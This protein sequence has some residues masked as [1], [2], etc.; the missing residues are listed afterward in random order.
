MKEKHTRPRSA[1]VPCGRRA[2]KPAG[3]R[4]RRWAFLGCLL[5][6]LVSGGLLLHDQV[7][8][9]R[10]REANAALVQQVR[11]AEEQLTTQQEEPEASP[12]PSDGPLPQ[13]QALAEQNPDFFGWIRIEGTQLD[14]PVMYTPDRPEYYL[15]RAFDGSYAISGTPFL[16]ENCFEGCG[17]LILY[18]HNMK[19]GSMFRTLLSYADQ[20]FWKEHPTVQFDT[21]ERQGTYEVLAAFYAQASSKSTEGT[22]P[23]Y[24]YYDLGD[25]ERFEEYLSLVKGAALYDTGVRAEYG[26]ELLTLSTCSYHVTNGRFVV[27]ARRSGPEQETQ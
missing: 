25:W 14:Y 22:F 2:A 6:F 18:G 27:V 4:W 8:A 3:G 26:D 11:Q 13:Y 1:D 10:E 5:V 16:E 23:Y 19:D 7:R 15:R 21:L 9:A 17:N 24:E 12:P 20:A